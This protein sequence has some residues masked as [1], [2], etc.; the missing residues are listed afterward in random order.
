MRRIFFQLLPPLQK[1]EV[2]FTT[3]GFS[4]GSKLL[5]VTSAASVMWHSHMRALQ[6]RARDLSLVLP[7]I[8]ASESESVMWGRLVQPFHGLAPTSISLHLSGAGDEEEPMSTAS[9]VA[10]V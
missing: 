1:L 6:L 10:M 4:E 3:S 5:G 2:D 9:L 8:H 7:E